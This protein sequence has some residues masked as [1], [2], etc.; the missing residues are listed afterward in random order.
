LCKYNTAV[1]ITF[2]I[3]GRKPGKILFYKWDGIQ[4]LDVVSGT[5]VGHSLIITIQLKKRG[6]REELSD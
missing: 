5:L 6:I 1:D 4:G 2:V 3:S